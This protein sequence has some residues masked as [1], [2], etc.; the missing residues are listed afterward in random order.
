MRKNQVTGQGDMGEGGQVTGER[1]QVRE[2]EMRV[3]QKE[4][5]EGGDVRQDE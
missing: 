2:K 4:A 3:W 1:A 5:G